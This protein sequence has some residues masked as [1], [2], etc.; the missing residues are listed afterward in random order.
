MVADLKQVVAD[1]KQVVADLK[2]VVAD[3]KL[4][5]Q[6]LKEVLRRSCRR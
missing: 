2:Q 5:K 3:L 6:I 4:D 1:L